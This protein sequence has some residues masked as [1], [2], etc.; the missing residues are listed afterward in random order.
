MSYQMQKGTGFESDFTGWLAEETGQP[1][2]R[3]VKHGAK[4]CGDVS[5]LSI[6][7]K[8]ACVELKN[9]KQVLLWKWLD[10][11]EV[12][13]RNAGAEW[14]VLC[15]KVPGCGRASMKRQLVAMDWEMWE[16]MAR[17]CKCCPGPDSQGL[18]KPARLRDYSGSG[19]I[20]EVA[21]Q[22]DG[23]RAAVMGL[24]L[25]NLMVLDV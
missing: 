20:W 14:G 17:A 2:E 16:R 4:D 23:R 11:T 24:G 8:P 18:W 19:R 12:E 25:W 3:R 10:E 6:A 1:V 5:G 15:I 7:G 22:G 13:R 9:A 21:K